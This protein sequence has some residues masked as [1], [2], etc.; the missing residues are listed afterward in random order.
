MREIT[1]RLMALR[2]PDYAAFTGRLLPNLPAETILGVRT[3]ALRGLARELR[4]SGEAAAFLD[5]LPHTYFEENCL[6]A[7]LLEQ[8]RDYEACMAAVERFLP[9]VDNWAVCDQMSPKAFR[10]HLPEL[11]ERVD[12]WLAS[13]ET[14]TVRFGVK[15]L[16]SWF[17][18]GAFRPEILDKV[19]IIESKEYYVNMMRAWFFATALAKQWEETLPLLEQGRLDPWT[20]GKTIQKAVESYRIPEERK[21]LLRGLRRGREGF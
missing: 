2:E 3:P 20:H 9:W 15:M 4:G 11:L 18:D 19:V 12:V 10:R 17:L 7:F 13:G 14:Y 8:I 5:E 16:M 1:S 21:A 6:H